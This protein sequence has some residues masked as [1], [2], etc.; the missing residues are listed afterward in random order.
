[1]CN[2]YGAINNK[3]RFLFTPRQNNSL[4]GPLRNIL[5]LKGKDLTTWANRPPKH[6]F[7]CIEHKFTLLR[8]SCAYAVGTTSPLCPPHRPFA[9]A[10]VFCI[11]GRTAD[12]IKHAKFQ[13]NR[14]RGFGATNPPG[15]DEIYSPPLTWHIALTFF[16]I[17][18]TNR[19]TP[20]CNL[21]MERPS[22]EYSHI[23]PY[24]WSFA[25]IVRGCASGYWW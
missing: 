3:G 8:V 19:L 14:L 10:I 7:D 25:Y 13:V 17:L 6:V 4:L 23:L 24:M 5:G 21:F 9:V 15:G 22:C 18:K 2:L 1:M 11:W 20:I 12:V 16:Y